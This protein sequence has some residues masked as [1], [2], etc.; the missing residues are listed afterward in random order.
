MNPSDVQ[1]ESGEQIRQAASQAVS[2][3]ADIRAKVHELTLAR[4]AAAALRSARHARGRARRHRRRRARRRA[5]PL[6]HAP[7]V[8]RRVQRPRPGDHEVGRSRAGGAAPARRVGQELFR[9]RVQAGAREPEE[10]RGRFPRHREPGGR[11]R[12]REGRPRAGPRARQRA[13]QRHADRQAGRADDG[14]VRAALHRRVARRDARRRAG[15]RRIRRALRDAGQ[16]HP[17]RRRRRAAPAGLRRQG[18]D[19]TPNRTE[20]KPEPNE[21]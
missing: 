20:Q 12:Q 6:R 16:R 4:A 8:V 10:D 18:R 7:R 11:R 3:G 14:R 19:E 17:L 5:G 21:S 13:H 1:A 2:H 15:R 9:Q